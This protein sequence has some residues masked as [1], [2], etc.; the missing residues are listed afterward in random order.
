LENTTI[1]EL[2]RNHGINTGDIV[3]STAGHDAN[4]IYIVFSVNNK[5]AQIGDGILKNPIH[6]K[7]KRVTHLKTIGVLKDLQYKECQLSKTYDTDGQNRLIKEW[8]AE[9]LSENRDNKK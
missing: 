5:I 7:N 6:P 3:I 2:I 1:L 8:I 9:F 4:R